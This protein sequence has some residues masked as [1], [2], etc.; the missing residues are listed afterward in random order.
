MEVILPL[1]I[2]VHALAGAVLL[3]AL[4]G[5]WIVLGLAQRAETLEAMVTL[6]RA[7]K[8]FERVVIMIPNVVVVLGIILVVAQGR[9][10]LGPFQGAPVDWLFVSIILVFSVPVLVPTVF[11]PRGR[12]FEA[13]LE[14]AKARGEVTPELRAAWRDPVTRAAQGLRAHRRLG[15]L[16]PDGGQAL[17]MPPRRRREGFNEKRERLGAVEDPAVVLEAALR[18]LEPRQRSIGEVRRRLT[19]VGY[20][21]DLVEGAITRLVEL[22]MLDDRRSHGRGSS[23]A[24][25]R[26]RVGERALRRSWRS[27]AS[28]ARPS[29]ATIE[30]ARAATPGCGRGG[31]AAAA[32]AQRARPGAGRRTRRR[33]GSAPTRCSPAT[34]STLRP[35][36]QPAEPRACRHSRTRRPVE[37]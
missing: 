5:R 7:A 29:T 25:A 20:R 37:D 21:A 22:G 6:T 24:T 15:R 16:R 32:R 8:P 19:R 33:A 28:I 12:V 26:G 13:A 18:F 23:R 14:E 31:R 30:R 3:G 10:F 17:L 1:V 9:P 11:I 35:R 34:G 27:R 2:A 36:R 4:I